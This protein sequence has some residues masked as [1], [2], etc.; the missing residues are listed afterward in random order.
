[1]NIDHVVVLVADLAKAQLH[2]QQG[3][4][5]VTP[6]GVHADGVTHNALVCFADGSY[7]EL[8]AFLKTPPA[9]HRWARFH[10]FWGPIDFVIAAP[11]VAA[12]AN[13]LRARGL[14]YGDVAEGGRKRPDG[15]ELRWRSAFPSDAGAALPFLIEDVTRRQLR[16]PDGN[17]ALHDNAATGIVQVRVDVPDVET[18]CDAYDSLFGEPETQPHARV[19]RLHGSRVTLNAPA[20]GSAE[21]N[22][23]QQRGA[24]VVAVTIGA[25]IPIVIKPALLQS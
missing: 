19:Y 3:G 17:A 22:F 21:A 12:L 6:G 2:W 14:P 13:D 11:D 25:P 4:F 15:V 1:M 10:G 5:T 7:I 16:V 20:A 24:G 18:A 8:L 9:S 23:I